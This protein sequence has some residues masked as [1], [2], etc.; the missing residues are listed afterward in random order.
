[1]KYQ[2]HVGKLNCDMLEFPVKHTSSKIRQFED[3]NTVSLNIYRYDP[4]YKAMPLQ[5]S[6]KQSREKVVDLLLLEDTDGNTH[7]T[8]L[9][10]VS[11]LMTGGIGHK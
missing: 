7:Y 8:W 5:I 10:N 2:E 4:K 3:V 6:E 11:H 1:M 9:K